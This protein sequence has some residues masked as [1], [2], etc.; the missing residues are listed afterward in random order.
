MAQWGLPRGPPWDA[1]ESQRVRHEEKDPVQ[2]VE[3]AARGELERLD[4]LGG[5]PIFTDVLPVDVREL[6][7]RFLQEEEGST[8]AQVKAQYQGIKKDEDAALGPK[9][10]YFQSRERSNRIKDMFDKE[11]RELGKDVRRS[12]R[13]K[14]RILKKR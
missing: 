14:R 5:R 8:P 2:V 4:D 12:L 13:V 11:R 10:A 7:T 3:S 9:Y 6:F 1:R